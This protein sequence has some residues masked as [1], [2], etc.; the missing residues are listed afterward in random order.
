MG[1][2]YSRVW[3]ILVDGETLIPETT[4]R[5]FK[6]I[7]ETIIDFGGYYSYCDI[8]LYNL[9]ID[10]AGKALQEGSILT[11]RAGYQENIG[12]IF[13]GR[14]K[15]VIYERVGNNIITRIKCQGGSQP[16]DHS[17]DVTLDGNVDVTTVIASIAEAMGYP[18]V[19]QEEDFAN[20]PS[21]SRGKVLIGDPYK[22]LSGLAKTF[23]FNFAIENN[24]L[25]VVSGDGFRPGTPVV[26]SE[27]L[28]MEGIPE[29]TENGVDVSVRLNPS[30]RVGILLDIQSEFR[31]FNFANL[32]FQDIPEDAG[33][34]EY[35]IWRIRHRGDSYGS[36]WSTLLTGFRT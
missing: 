16:R 29:I 31:T 23:N 27:S 1:S 22:L 33:V 8:K 20:S 25:V 19:I 36:D 11:L 21:F 17:I 6:I 28:G 15:N 9:G 35:K 5:Q 3:S 30:V 26:I 7:F 12:S 14:I 32:Y 4:E 34:G 2:F 13:S 24:R 10:E 18:L